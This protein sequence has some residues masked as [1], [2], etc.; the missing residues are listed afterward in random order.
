MPKRVPSSL[1]RW[2]SSPHVS[3]IT[4]TFTPSPSPSLL[5]PSPSLLTPSPSPITHHP[6]PH[7]P[8]PTSHLSPSSSP[9]LLTP[10]SSLLTPHS[11]LLTPHSSPLLLTLT[12]TPTGGRPVRRQ[13]HRLAL[14]DGCG[15][16]RVDAG[17]AAKARGRASQRRLTPSRL[18]W[19]ELS[20]R[21]NPSPLTPHSSPLTPHSSLLT[22][23]P[24]PL[25]PHPSLLTPGMRLDDFVSHPVAI[26]AG[27][28][29]AHVLAIRLYTSSV[30]C[31]L[32]HVP[33]LSLSLCLTHTHMHTHMHTH[34]HAHLTPHTSPLAPRPSPLAPRPSP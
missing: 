18:S 31:P 28:K 7:L 15:L 10:H 12:P 9:S 33:A 3:P 2:T 5:T 1:A 27:L 25:T 21:G 29:R 23:H 24:S 22:P 13:V 30:L 4:I 14:P 11:S 20:G 8:P 6:R 16:D 32:K 34:T 19:A 26:A 17:C